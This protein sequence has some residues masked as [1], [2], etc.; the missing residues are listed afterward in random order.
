[1]YIPILFFYFLVFY[2]VFF[3]KYKLL[4]NYE[5]HH[6][7]VC[8][9]FFLYVIIPQPLQNYLLA[10]VLIRSLASFT[11]IRFDDIEEHIFPQQ[12]FIVEVFISQFISVWK[13]SWSYVPAT[14]QTKKKILLAQEIPH[15]MKIIFEKTHFTLPATEL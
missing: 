12:E 8:L 14:F 1:M 4:Y 10:E 15:S 11:G 9:L 2:E 3:F 5:T 7:Q 13:A 6:N